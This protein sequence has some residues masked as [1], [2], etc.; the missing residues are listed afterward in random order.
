MPL[1]SFLAGAVARHIP[2]L[3]LQ[4][5]VLISPPLDS[6]CLPSTVM[7]RNA[8]PRRSAAAYDTCVLDTTPAAFLLP[9]YPSTV[10]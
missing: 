1:S 3:I 5:F 4:L 7:T 8:T 10:R 2:T 6:T 9:E